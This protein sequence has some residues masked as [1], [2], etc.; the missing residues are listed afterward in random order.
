MTGSFFTISDIIE[1]SSKFLAQPFPESLCFY[2]VLSSAFIYLY[3]E[4]FNL[5]LYLLGGTEKRQV[6]GDLMARK[7][8]T[9]LGQ[10]GIYKMTYLEGGQELL[11]VFEIFT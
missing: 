5:T 3:I 9:I 1:E 10:E 4:I 8:D 2:F 11:F 7:G 6:L